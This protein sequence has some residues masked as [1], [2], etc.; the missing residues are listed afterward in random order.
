MTTCF[1]DMALSSGGKAEEIFTAIDGCMLSY[2]I[3]WENCVAVGINNT[4]VNVGKNNSHYDV[5]SSM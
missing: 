4:N 5:C 3:L 1:L 2:E